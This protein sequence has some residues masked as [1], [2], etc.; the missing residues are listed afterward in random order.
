MKKSGRG[1]TA[2]EIMIVAAIIGI[3]IAIA[4]PG[5]QKVRSESRRRQCE[6][7]LT[8]IDGAKEQWA[9]EKNK[10]AGTVVTMEE[11]LAG[12]DYLKKEYQCPTG[13]IYTINEVGKYPACSIHGSLNPALPREAVPS[14]LKES[15]IA[16]SG[17]PDVL[18]KLERKKFVV[19][20]SAED[21]AN[22][23]KNGRAQVTVRTVP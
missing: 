7:N 17:D 11:L 4:V 9:L 8:R 18:K 13:G 22:L 1:F 12:G 16:F 10:T 15:S 23:E 20:V 21:A 5:F 3:L 19:D 2:M 6:E 14:R